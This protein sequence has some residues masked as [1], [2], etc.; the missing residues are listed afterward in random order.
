MLAFDRSKLL[1]FAKP[2]VD[3]LL[4]DHGRVAVD[5]IQLCLDSVWVHAP[6]TKA[7]V[8]VHGPSLHEAIPQNVDMC[9]VQRPRRWDFGELEL[10]T[11][12]RTLDPH[13]LDQVPA[14]PVQQGNCVRVLAC[15]LVVVVLD[16]AT[17]L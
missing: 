16:L 10:A 1:R 9:N 11:Q 7:K 5:A 12:P 13:V 3:A 2:R 6:E 8:R 4:V 15:A 17:I 14:L